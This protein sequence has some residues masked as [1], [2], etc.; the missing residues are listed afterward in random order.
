MFI[1]KSGSK[2]RAE[3]LEKHVMGVV[4]VDAFEIKR[5]NVFKEISTNYKK[6]SWLVRWFSG[7]RHL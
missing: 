1:G 7:E 4:V 2:S 3:G 5:T 6:S